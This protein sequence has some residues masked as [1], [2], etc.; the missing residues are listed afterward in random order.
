MIAICNTNWLDK[1][2]S[3]Y[4]RKNF[5]CGQIAVTPNSIARAD[6][7]RNEFFSRDVDSRLGK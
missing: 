7:S 6:I 2:L 1:I 4:S 5:C 3:G